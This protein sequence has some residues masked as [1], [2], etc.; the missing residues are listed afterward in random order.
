MEPHGDFITGP[1]ANIPD[2]LTSKG[3]DLHQIPACTL[4]CHATGRLIRLDEEI[5][6]SSRVWSTATGAPFAV[7]AKYRPEPC[8]IT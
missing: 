5:D 4:N 6:P 1:I 3:H 7:A 2:R 8:P